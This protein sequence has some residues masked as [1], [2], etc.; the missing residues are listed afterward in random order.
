MTRK[1]KTKKLKEVY[2]LTVVSEEYGSETFGP[3]DSY[4]EAAK[5][6]HRIAE[7]A[8]ND[9]VMRSYTLEHIQPNE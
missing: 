3:Y 5:V 7:K 9:G 8:V 2:T 4:E 1:R 6:M